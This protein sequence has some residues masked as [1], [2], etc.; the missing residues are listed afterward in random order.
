MCRCVD[1]TL[2]DGDEAIEI[3]VNSYYA[4]TW[5]LLVLIYRSFEED[6]KRSSSI[7]INICDILFAQ[8]SKLCIA[9]FTDCI[10]RND[11]AI[12]LRHSLISCNTISSL[13]LLS[14]AY[15]CLLSVV[16]NWL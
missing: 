16:V 2:I 13:F 7:N 5:P 4:K 3:M 1:L 9:K 8:Q 15:L 14:I 10:S 12:K 6:L 11:V